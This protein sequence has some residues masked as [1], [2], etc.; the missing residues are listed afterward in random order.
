MPQYTDI[1][2]QGPS[3]RAKAHLRK[4]PKHLMIQCLV[5]SY[6]CSCVRCL[7]QQASRQ[8]TVQGEEAIFADNLRGDG[9]GAARSTQL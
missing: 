7:T 9:E 5:Y 4:V 1:K 6:A 8:A 2:R 3:G